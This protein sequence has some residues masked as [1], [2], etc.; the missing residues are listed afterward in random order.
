MD[1][2]QKYMEE[3]KKDK[4]HLM[5]IFALGVGVGGWLISGRLYHLVEGFAIGVLIFFIVYILVWQYVEKFFQK[6]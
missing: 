1:E 2:E 5:W 6:K 4:S 3:E